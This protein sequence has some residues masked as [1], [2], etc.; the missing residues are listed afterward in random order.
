MKKSFLLI[1]LSLVIFSCK[2]EKS[3]SENIQPTLIRGEF[4]IVS[5]AA[6]IKGD[7]FIYGVKLNEMTDELSKRVTPLKREEY[8]MVPV[9]ING[10]IRPNTEE[11][12]EKIVEITEI[13]NVAAPTSKLPVKIKSSKNEENI[14]A[15]SE[16][17]KT[18]KES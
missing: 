5:G 15:G 11:G 9:V 12:W 18:E 4:I 13:I 10:I 2:K 7:D 3:D 6:V 17:E 14:D 16:E 8:D 1:I